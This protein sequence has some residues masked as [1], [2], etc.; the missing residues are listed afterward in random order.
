MTLYLA[1]KIT[2][3]DNYRNKFNKAAKMLEGLGYTVLS[4]SVLPSKGFSYD[5]YIRMSTVMMDECDVVC[6]L[7]DWM[8]SPGAKKEFERAVEHGKTVLMYDEV[9]NER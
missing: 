1:G 3:D 2:G 6:F 8:D 7:P 4:P 5:A 9:Q